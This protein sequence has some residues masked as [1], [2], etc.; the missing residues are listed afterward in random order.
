MDLKPLNRKQAS[1]ILEK[2]GD[3]FGCDAKKHMID[4]YVF[5][6]SERNNKIYIINNAI[7]EIDLSKIRANSIGLYFCEINRDEIRLSMEGSF[8][9][10]KIATKNVVELDDKKARSWLKGIDVEHAEK[11]DGFAIIK[12]KTTDGNA[13]DFLGSGKWRNGQILNFVPKPRRVME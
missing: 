7:K 11:F 12:H 3:A 10:G 9:I 13:D 4:S 5:F 2:I 8:I 6:L 1:E